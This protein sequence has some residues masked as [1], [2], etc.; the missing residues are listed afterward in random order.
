MAVS[1]RAFSRLEKTKRV[2]WE[3]CAS[4]YYV[5]VISSGKRKY[6][7]TKK[8]VSSFFLACGGLYLLA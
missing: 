5:I 3:E 8:L 4:T 2:L 1:T 6:E 7:P